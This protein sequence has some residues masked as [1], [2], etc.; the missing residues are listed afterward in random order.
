MQV[1]KDPFREARD[2]NGVLMA[3]FQGEEIPMLLRHRDLLGAVKDW[4]TFSSNAPFRVP[5]PSE[6]SVRKVQQLPIETDPPEH[7]EYRSLVE[8]F[9]KRPKS[10]EMKARVEALV[11]RFVDKALS[12][13]KIEVVEDFALPIQSKALAILLNM[14]EREADEWITW[15]TNVFIDEREESVPSEGHDKESALSSGKG[16]Q[17]DAYIHRQLDRAEAQPGDDFF[18]T[19]VQAEFQGR[20]LTREECVGFA[21]LTFAGGRDTVI[22]SIANIIFYLGHHPKALEALREDPRL[23]FSATEEF[24][25]VGSP[26]THI[27]RVCPHATEHAGAAIEAGQRVSMCWAAANMDPD[28]FDAPE[29]VRL[30]RRPNPHV[31]FGKGVHNC[32]GA[33]HARN[34]FHILLRELADKVAAIEIRSA[35]PKIEKE[36]S[37]QRENGYLKLEVSLKPRVEGDIIQSNKP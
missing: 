1:T 15:G 3:K 34:L 5:I 36:I 14:D 21:N 20:P 16:D 13:E 32:L 23:V 7:T 11:G 8:P 4:E 31:A 12:E 22:N 30:D 25:R 29:E 27:G 10:P 37:Y 6:E 2:E 28:V 18:S 17:L 26:L 9:F 19:L 24:M 35:R 33:L